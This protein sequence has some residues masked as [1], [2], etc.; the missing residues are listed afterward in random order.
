MTTSNWRPVHGLA[1]FA[2]LL[3]LA[4]IGLFETSSFRVQAEPVS[5]GA[6]ESHGHS[7][8]HDHEDHDHGGHDHGDHGH[9]HGGH[10]HGTASE[11]STVASSEGSRTQLFTLLGIYTIFIAGA[12]LLGGWLPSQ[13]RISHL[14][15]QCLLSV[16]GGML[17]GIGLFHLF[18]HAVHELGRNRVEFAVNWMLAGILA[19]FFLLRTLHVHHHEPPALEPESDGDPADEAHAHIGCSHHHHPDTA[20]VSWIGSFLGLSI[21]T[22]LDGLALGASMQAEAFH[23]PGGWLGLGV[24]A[25]IVLHKPLDSLSFT[26]LMVQAGQSKTR[27]VVFNVIYSLLCPIGAALFLL[28]VGSLGGQTSLIVGASLAFSAGIFLCIALADLLPEMEFHSH[29]RWLLSFFLIIG[30]ALAWAIRFLEPAHLH[31]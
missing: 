16:V 28:G 6:E 11:H 17:L 18:P 31:H 23:H 3:V 4:G 7:H 1:F 14:S 5:Q 27:R 29:N 19:M 15:F 21:H 22:L 9:N 2:A 26:T 8:D 12:S 13:I 20:G 24:L 10:D 30:I 25:G